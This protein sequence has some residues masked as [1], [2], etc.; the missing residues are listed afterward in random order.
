MTRRSH[1]VLDNLCQDICFTG[2]MTDYKLIPLQ[3]YMHLHVFGSHVVIKKSVCAKCSTIMI[4]W[5]RQTQW[6]IKELQ[7]VHLSCTRAM[8]VRLS[9]ESRAR[10]YREPATQAHDTCAIRHLEFNH[11][12][13][14][15]R[16]C[17]QSD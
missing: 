7:D 3:G 4:S 8:H 15:D 13:G 16:Q 2:N 5:S 1:D 17:P 12:F 9:I 10:K 6:L 14:L 11:A